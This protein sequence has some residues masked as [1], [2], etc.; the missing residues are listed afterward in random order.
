MAPKERGA[1][2]GPTQQERT[3]ADGA[4]AREAAP[5]ERG[6]ADGPTQ[7]ERTAADGAE[8]I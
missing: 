5:K 6:A 4:G 8:A 1:D 7:Q 3:A 2:D